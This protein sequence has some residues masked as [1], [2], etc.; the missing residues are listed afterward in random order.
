ML[1]RLK[2]YVFSPLWSFLRLL[3]TPL[4]LRLPFYDSDSHLSDS[5]FHLSDSVLRAVWR[6]P[7][8]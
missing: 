8:R 4:R 6:A 5:G 1:P 7:R 2:L 3:F